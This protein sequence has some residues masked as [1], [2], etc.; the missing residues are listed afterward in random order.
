MNRFVVGLSVEFGVVG[1]LAFL[2]LYLHKKHRILPRFFTLLLMLKAIEEKT[3]SFF[4]FYHFSMTIFSLLHFPNYL[5]LLRHYYLLDFSRTMPPCPP[6]P[7]LPSSHLYRLFRTEFVAR[8]PVPLCSD[9]FS[10]FLRADPN[11]R[12]CFLSFSFPWFLGIFLHLFIFLF[13]INSNTMLNS[14]SL[15]P[16]FLK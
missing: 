7:E 15:F 16:L 6:D 1:T 14:D 8:Y 2:F 4:H 5:P 13:F 3:G 9:G 12:V 11:R 10:G